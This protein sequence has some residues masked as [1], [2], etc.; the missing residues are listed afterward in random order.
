MSAQIIRYNFKKIDTDI[1]FNSQEISDFYST[2]SLHLPPS[3]NEVKNDCSYTSS[4]P[5]RPHNVDTAYFTFTYYVLNDFE[6]HSATV[7]V[8]VQSN[9]YF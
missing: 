8:L 5:T 9:V 2:T 7:S 4:P 1:S 6:A 3:R